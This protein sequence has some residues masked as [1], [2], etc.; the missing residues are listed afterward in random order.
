MKVG[1]IGTGYM[2]F[3]MAEKL[4]ESGY[5]IVVFNRTIQKAN[6]LEEKGAAV[7]KSFKEACSLS[8]VILLV[9]SDFGAIR[10][11]LDSIELNLL[12]GKT[13]IQMSTI[14][15]EESINLCAQLKAY[16]CEYAEAPVLGSIPQIKEKSLIIFYGGE[17][18]TLVKV[19]P[20]FDSFANRVEIIGKIGD[21]SAMKLSVNQLIV[22]LTTIFSMS[23]GFVR[24]SNL[25]VDQFMS[26][27]RGS[28]LNAPTY[29]KKLSNYLNRHYENP[30]FPLK[31]LLKD[32][33]L[34][35]DSFED[36]RINTVVLEGFQK[37][38]ESGLSNNLGEL[39]YSALYEV[40]HPVK[41]SA[42]E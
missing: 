40:I 5:E 15:S 7:A 34:I 8:N 22:G 39:D 23:L 14:K 13:L 26:I 1:V 29:D 4:I 20:L 3:P 42:Q 19:K 2:G 35:K 27:I 24:E 31:H 10:E 33:N 37:I 18:K 32:L 11:L 30:N 25:S 12:S 28:A 6:P 41:L 17:E 36:K 38:L 9:L 21:A 16:N